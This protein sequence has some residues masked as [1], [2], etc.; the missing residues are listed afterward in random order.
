[1]RGTASSCHSFFVC[2]M[3]ENILSMKGDYLR[4][5]SVFPL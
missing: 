5:T 2:K 3:V 1:M 4:I